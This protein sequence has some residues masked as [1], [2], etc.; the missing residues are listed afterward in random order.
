M[1][2]Y[3]RFSP[4]TEFAKPI[5]IGLIYEADGGVRITAGLTTVEGDIAKK[6]ELEVKRLKLGDLIVAVIDAPLEASEDENQAYQIVSRVPLKIRGC[7]APASAEQLI[8]VYREA[9]LPKL[10]EELRFPNF[11]KES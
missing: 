1:F 4:G 9:P 8:A 7:C 2:K 10:D 5:T 3:R 11:A 6:P